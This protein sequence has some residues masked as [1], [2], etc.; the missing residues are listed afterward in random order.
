MEL[1]KWTATEDA[2]T[3]LERLIIKHCY[4]LKKIPSTFA[5]LYTLRL[6]ELYSCDSLLVHSAK[7]IQQLQQESIG[8]NLFGVH[9]YNTDKAAASI[10]EKEQVKRGNFEEQ[11]RKKLKCKASDPES[12][13]FAIQV[14]EEVDPKLTNVEFFNCFEDDFDNNDIN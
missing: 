10:E 9:D 11:E 14:V 8:D 2:F 12:S 1:K 3:I 4:N 13:N 7:Q 6:I 5:E